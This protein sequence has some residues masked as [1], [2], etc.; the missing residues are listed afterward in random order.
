MLYLE[1]R[2]RRL[3]R[4]KRA[5]DA[6]MYRWAATALKDLRATA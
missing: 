3:D 1:A 5:A 2:A 6:E 4:H